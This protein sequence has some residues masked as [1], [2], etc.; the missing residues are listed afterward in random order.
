MHELR[1]LDPA[2]E[3]ATPA[4]QPT[5]TDPRRP[6]RQHHGDPMSDQLA[7]TLRRHNTC[8]A[9]LRQQFST[10]FEE[11]ALFARSNHPVPAAVS[12]ELR[13]LNRRLHA[14]SSNVGHARTLLYEITGS[15]Y[16]LE[17]LTRC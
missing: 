6:A 4:A 9:Q 10:A 14:V 1:L 5:A 3:C 7:S 17:E 15:A 11:A 2:T 13:A 12:E 16:L 8:L